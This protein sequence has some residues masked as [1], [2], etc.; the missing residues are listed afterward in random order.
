MAP[1][2]MKE[3]REAREAHTAS[4]LAH[5]P[6]KKIAKARFDELSAEL[7]RREE[8]SGKPKPF[9]LD[10][11]EGV[12]PFAGEPLEISPELKAIIVGGPR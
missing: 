5:P 2:R 8:E 11:I 10:L 9:M 12:D 1:A 4:I 6:L 3:A 7:E